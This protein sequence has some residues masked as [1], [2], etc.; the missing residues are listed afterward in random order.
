MSRLPVRAFSRNTSIAAN[1][2]EAPGPALKLIASS[3]AGANL[4]NVTQRSAART[5]GSSSAKF[6]DGRDLRL[7]GQQF[8][9]AHGIIDGSEGIDATILGQAERIDGLREHAHQA[10]DIACCRGIDALLGVSAAGKAA[11]DHSVSHIQRGIDQPC[12]ELDHQRS[13]RG[14]AA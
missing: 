8:V 7:R 2:D 10:T 3:R 11:T 4:R 9:P 13:E 5:S 1:V 14:P 12:F 6:A